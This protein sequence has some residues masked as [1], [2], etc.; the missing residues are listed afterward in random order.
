VS[1]EQIHML[2]LLVV[3]VL[4]FVVPLLLKRIRGVRIP[5][6]VGEIL[7]GMVVGKSGLNLVHVD[8][9]LQLLNFLGLVSLM[10]VSG[11]EI[12]FDVLIGRGRRG[13][14]R[15]WKERLYQPLLLGGLF[16]F[17]TLAGAWYFAGIL[18]A[19]GFVRSA[20]LLAL[21]IGTAALSMAVP[22]L[23]EMGLM[24]TRF[25]QTL[26]AG[27][28]IGDFVTMVALTVGVSLYAG[29][30]SLRT[31][32]VLG[33]L[34][35]VIA[36]YRAGLLLSRFRLLEGLSGGTAQIGVCASFAAMLVF[37]ALAQSLG[38]E[39]VLGAFLA[40]A[41]MSLL[42]GHA[43]EEVSH[44]LDA[45]GFGFLIPIFFL[46]V[47]INFDFRVL[48]RDPRA[49]LFVPI[50]LG[51]TLL[52]RGLPP[53][54]LLMPF[55]KP[56]QA[57][58]GG[59]LMAAQMS[60][61]IAAA[62]VVLRSGAISESI[63]AAIV[64]V[65]ILLAVLAPIAFAKLMPHQDAVR[66]PVFIA[67]ANALALRIAQR[68]QRTGPVLLMDSDPAKVAEAER[69]GLRAIAGDVTEP[70]AVVAALGEDGADGLVALT[71]SDEVNVGAARLGRE[72][73]GLERSFALVREASRWEAARAEGVEAINP[74]LAS[75]TLIENLL[76]NPGSAGLLQGDP[77]D[78]GLFDVALG[79]PAFTGHRLREVR[80]P[81]GALVAAIGRG[82]EKLIPHG[83]TRLEPG[84]V[85]T[86]VGP[87][88]SQEELRRQLG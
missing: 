8:A 70:G 4:A 83:D 67:G 49:L 86:L 74:E 85:L 73:L 13:A 53:T 18:A 82:R 66:P 36:A 80:L 43:R 2:P 72:V 38:V 1:E 57:L 48:V 16:L 15:T 56:R 34:I 58:A 42:S 20:P 29:G 64:L 78:I 51:V 87:R 41:L 11:L 9:T 24:P 59:A 55:V 63:H 40:G 12:D 28:V 50:L 39:V 7:A 60:V 3:T 46:V 6:A 61:T 26:L 22:V 19:R 52:V 25:G 54:L 65:V 77:D 35:A 33:L 79:N 88:A 76:A 81:D 44:K 31:V 23:K 69:F 45:L 21:I 30:F 37:V 62:A 5:T 47:G 84:D 27:A 17:F 75:I 32:L 68:L 14:A 10:F 71:G